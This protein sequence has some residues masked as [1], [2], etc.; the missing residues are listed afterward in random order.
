M[1]INLHTGIDQLIFGMKQN[2]VINAYGKPD[3]TYNDEE[4]NVVLVYNKPKFRLTFYKEEDL[5]L[6]YIVSASTDLELFGFKIIGRPMAE[7][8]KDLAT[9][10]IIKYLS[11]TIDTLDNEFNEENWFILQAEFN[12]IVKFELGALINDDDEF[13]WKFPA[14]KK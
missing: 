14:K 8:K 7:V 13:E 3:K 4:D 11:E 9:K 6:G 2:D 10:K 1:K 5:R 12:E